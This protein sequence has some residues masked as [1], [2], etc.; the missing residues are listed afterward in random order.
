MSATEAEHPP[1]PMTRTQKLDPPTQFDA[2]RT[3]GPIHRITQWNGE[4]AWALF[5]HEGV[6]AV[7]RDAE[8]FRSLPAT[9]GFPTINAADKAT[10]SS[11]LLTML[12]APEHTVLRDVVRQEFTLREIRKHE[13]E[14][15]L[16]VER[17]L[18]DIAAQAQP[19]ELIAVL[20]APLPA[21]FTCRLL[22]VPYE[23]A[24][25]F[26]ECI[27]VRFASGSPAASVYQ[28][29]DRLGKY[30]GD[31]VTDR[32]VT[33]RDDMASRVAEQ[34]RA[35]MITE[36]AAAKLL[37]IL[38]I[39]GFDT[40]KQMISLGTLMLL[41]HPDQLALLMAD[42]GL[43]P[44]AIEELL[45][46]LSV[47]QVERRAC[48]ADTQIAGQVIRAGE[49]VLV[50]FN[51]ANRD[52]EVF[53]DPDRFDIRRMDAPHVA[54][55]F[56]VHQCLGQHVA[57]LLLGIA[58]PRLFRRFPGLAVAVPEQDLVFRDDGPLISVQSLPMVWDA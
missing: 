48:T 51:A 10:K 40:T 44:R 41:R 26:T 56:G 33:P 22:G 2:W 16:L 19:A 43:W 30:F 35:G 11:A 5:G 29:E 47:V 21:R 52:P 20:A 7:L 38:L 25:F 9:P 13:E 31:L 50:M 1:L 32:L 3:E 4:T 46:Y 57:R 6:R 24:A 54:F 55:G 12:D 27:E 14:T 18:D 45:R 42:H 37:H 28:V 49:G 34:V 17:L 8:T 39:G 15:E 36:E 53:R 23:D 58:L